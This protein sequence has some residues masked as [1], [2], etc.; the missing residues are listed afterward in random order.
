MS[1]KLHLN[2]RPNPALTVSRVAIPEAKLVYV[3]V[4]NKK[5]KYPFG[6]SAIAYVG[7]TKKGLTRIAQSAAKRAEKIV[8]LH[9]VRSVSARVV[10]CARRQ[11]VNS[12]LKLERAVL[13]SFRERYGA[14][15][16]CNSHGKKMVELDEF[17]YFSRGA[18]RRLVDKLG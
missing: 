1:R 18:I 15:P 16:Y 10:T 8:S 11:N 12:W 7:T 13:L 5:L 2:L 14:V 9:G 3:L 6:R 4:A 17:E